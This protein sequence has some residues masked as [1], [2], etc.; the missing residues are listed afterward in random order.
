MRLCL[1]LL[2][3]VLTAAMAGAQ[4]ANTPDAAAERRRS[5]ER[6]AAELSAGRRVEAAR[7]LRA[8][9]DRYESVQALVQL[10]RIQSGEGDAP[11][12]LDTLRQARQLAPNSE[13]VLSAFAQVSLAARAPLPAIG[14][15]EP[16]TRICPT[17]AQYQYLLGVA[18][19][20][21]GD[22]VAA[23][24]AL[25]HAERLEP[26]RVLTLVALGLALNARKQYS[27]AEPRL[28][29]SLELQPENI[30]AVAALAESQEGIGSVEEAE[31]LARRVLASSAA[32]ATA[33]LVMGLVL[34]K[35]N[36]Y[37]EARDALV[38]AVAA[39]PSS[40]RAHYQL[41]LAYARLGDRTASERHLDLYRRR[42]RE[43]EERVHAV[44][45]RTGL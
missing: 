43:M 34:M 8:A 9:A 21:A 45:N 5:L 32:H 2:S 12:A 18:L 15:L 1:C 22:L 24:D 44:R 6:A 40:A 38:N 35:Q 10:A 13:E 20:Q 28:R 39:D 26:D 23:V 42:L 11:G 41:S 14:A 25:Q 16:L 36:R 33:N 30:E 37:A 31:S 17:V 4:D 27:D 29:R 3:V 19:M 7:L